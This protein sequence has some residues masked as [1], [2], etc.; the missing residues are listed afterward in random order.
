MEYDHTRA[1]M[2]H[3]F[4]FDLRELHRFGLESEQ[5]DYME[6]TARAHLKAKGL[7]S[8]GGFTHVVYRDSFQE[9]T[10]FVLII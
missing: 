5:Y 4:Y 10:T 6:D 2:V 3:T 8:E 1:A 7:T 9:K